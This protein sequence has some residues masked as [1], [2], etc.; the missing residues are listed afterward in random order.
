[1]NKSESE[2]DRLRKEGWNKRFVANEPRLSEAVEMYREA[3]FEV[4]LEPLSE[5]PECDSCVG[6]EEVDN[7]R[8]CFEGTE[9]QYKIIFTRAKEGISESEDN[10]F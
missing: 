8:I 10:L 6:D 1:M 7:C 3:G 9:D 4:H 5:E 2:E